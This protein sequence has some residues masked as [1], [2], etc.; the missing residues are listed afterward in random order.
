MDWIQDHKPLVPGELSFMKHKD[1]FVAL[2]DGQE[3]GWLDGVVEDT[4]NWCLPGR[5]MKV[6]YV[7]KCSPDPG[8]RDGK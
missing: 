6:G 8:H 1:D 3:C 7:T 2:S 4:L 5:L